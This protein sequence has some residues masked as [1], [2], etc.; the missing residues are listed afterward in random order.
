MVLTSVCFLPEACVCVSANSLCH[1]CREF[2]TTETT[3]VQSSSRRSCRRTDEHVGANKRVIYMFCMKMR[4]MFLQLMPVFHAECRHLLAGWIFDRKMSVFDSTV[5]NFLCVTALKYVF[6]KIY[7]DI[8]F[9]FIFH[10][11]PL[12][13]E[14]AGF[15]LKNAPSWKN[16]TFPP[17][18]KKLE[19]SFVFF[20][21]VSHSL[22]WTPFWF[23]FEFCLPLRRFWRADCSEREETTNHTSTVAQLIFWSWVCRVTIILASS[24]AMRF[25][26]L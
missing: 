7:K 13:V 16:L 9:C 25:C 11:V 18:F 15:K 4:I 12:A 3:G 21:S 1:S 23:L 6:T 8:Y 24:E 20:L 10:L 2:R 26:L 22:T 17:T 5:T 19:N 14:P